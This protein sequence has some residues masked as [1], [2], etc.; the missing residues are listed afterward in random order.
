MTMIGQLAPCHW[1]HMKLLTPKA[2]D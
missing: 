2:G 1:T